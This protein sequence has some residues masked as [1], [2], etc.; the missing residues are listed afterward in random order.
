MQVVANKRSRCRRL[1]RRLPYACHTL[2][3]DHQQ[4]ALANPLLAAW[5]HPQVFLGD[6]QSAERG[7]VSEGPKCNG[8]Q[9]CCTSNLPRGIEDARNAACGT[10][11][12]SL[13]KTM[14]CVGSVGRMSVLGVCG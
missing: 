6:D 2:P 4:F 11:A 9:N 8:M 7:G 5:C 3:N 14:Y 13:N 1:W 12:H 10:R